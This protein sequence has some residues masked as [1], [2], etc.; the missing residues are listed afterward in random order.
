[1]SDNVNIEPLGIRVLVRPIEQEAKTAS[2]LILPDSAKE[3]P[4]IGEVIAVGDDEEMMVEVGQK[5]LFPKYTGTEIKLE[6]VEH[7][8]M[9]ATDL[10]AIVK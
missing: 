5:V 2:G 7:I 10:L 4:Q 9:D 6:G 8:I 1:M 3:K